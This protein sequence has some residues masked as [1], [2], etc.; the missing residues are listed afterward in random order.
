MC[1]SGKE[2]GKG[3]R[4]RSVSPSSRTGLPQNIRNALNERRALLLLVWTKAAERGKGGGWTRGSQ[5]AADGPSL[6]TLSLAARDQP[7][8]PTPAAPRSE[9]ASA[10]ECTP[11]S[12]PARRRARPGSGRPG[13]STGVLQRTAGAAGLRAYLVLQQ[14][15]LHAGLC[16]KLEV[17]HVPLFNELA[18]EIAKDE[19]L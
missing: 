3:G 11:V 18:F 8:R 6:A 10:A 7:L 9:I 13:V 19:L 14:A 2:T 17:L 4:G 15:V 12:Q 16:F 5:G 1:V